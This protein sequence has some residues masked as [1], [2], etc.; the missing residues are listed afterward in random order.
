MLFLYI[1]DINKIGSHLQVHI[2]N[3]SICDRD[4]CDVTI[5]MELSWPCQCDDST[6]V[7]TFKLNGTLA[8]TTHMLL[9]EYFTNRTTIHEGGLVFSMCDNHCCELCYNSRSHDESNNDKTELALTVTMATL[10]AILLAMMIII[11][12][13]YQ[14]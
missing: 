8:V 7:Y 6:S 10:I 14:W 3:L 5:V 1:Q 4:C 13:S 9:E 11:L 2:N 12:L